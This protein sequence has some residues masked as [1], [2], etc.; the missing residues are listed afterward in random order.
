MGAATSVQKAV[1]RVAF[2]PTRGDLVVAAYCIVFL[3]T[4]AILPP[5]P[6][7]LRIISAIAYFGIGLATM[8]AQWRLARG[9]EADRGSRLGW[10]WLAQP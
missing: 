8:L 1:P 4:L 7:A 6:D 5:G 3:A 2:R 9:H 10:G